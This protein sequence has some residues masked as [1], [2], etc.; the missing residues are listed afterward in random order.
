MYSQG[1]PYNSPV[2]MQYH[3]FWSRFTGEAF[4]KPLVQIPSAEL[5][6]GLQVENLAPVPIVY[7]RNNPQMQ[8][9]LYNAEETPNLGN[10]TGQFNINPVDTMDVQG[11]YYGSA[12]GGW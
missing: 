2:D 3:N 11:A 8:P 5:G 7:V 9:Q 12:S 6:V 1:I 10:E 4:N